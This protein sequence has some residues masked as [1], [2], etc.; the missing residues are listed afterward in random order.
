[1]KEPFFHGN[2]NYDQL[3]KINRVLGTDELYQYLEKYNIELDSQTEAALTRHDKKNL[4]AFVTK[5]NEHLA[6]N[7]AIDLLS[8]MLVYD[9]V[10]FSIK[11]NPLG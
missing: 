11:C 7:E 1:M 4:K 9:H 8:R 5:D 3:E 2:D 10:I 6:N